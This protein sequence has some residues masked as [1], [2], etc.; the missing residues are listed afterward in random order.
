MAKRV[1]DAQIQRETYDSHESDDDMT[2]STKVA[3]S[4][5]MNRRKI[6]MPKRRMAFKSFTSASSDETKSANSFDTL[7][8]ANNTEGKTD[9]HLTTGNNSKLKALNF[10]FKTK[11]NDVISSKPLTDLRPLFAKYE[12]YIK[13]ILQASDK[14]SE[15]PKETVQENGDK[16][17]KVEDDRKSSDSSSEDEVK[18]EGPKFTIDSKPPTSDSVF[19]FG[20]KKENPQKD[21][22]DSESD[23]EIKGPEFKFSGALSSDVFKLNPSTDK[24]EKKIDANAKP[25]SFSSNA[26]NLTSGKTA[27]K[28]PFSFTESSET[29]EHSN[30]NIKPSFTFGAKDVGESQ[31]NKPSFAFGQ[32]AGKQSTEKSSFTFGLSK[33]ENKEDGNA[34]STSKSEN[35]GDDN[36]AKSSFTFPIPSKNTP[37]TTKPSFSFGVPNSSN[38]TS[39]PA[40]LFGT[41]TPPAKETNKNSGDGNGDKITPKPAFNFLSNTS[42]EKE[43]ENQG[44]SKPLFSFGKSNGSESKGSVN[45]T[46]PSEFNNVNEEKDVAKP[47]FSFG[48]NTNTAVNTDSKAPAFT[49]GS[50]TLADNKEDKKKPFSFGNSSSNDTPSFSFGKATAS[51]TTASSKSPAPPIPSTGFKFSLP[52]EQK[53]GQTTT[54]DSKKESTT[55]AAKND[56]QGTSK[57]EA[58][59]EESKPINLQNGEENEVAL[60]SERA[61]LMT[62]NADTKS[63]DSRGVGEMK[64]LKK[65]DDPSKVR[66]LCRS[67]GMGNI[68][69]NAT[70]VDSFKYEYLAPGNENLIKTPTVA[71]DGKLVTYI[72]KFKQK[73]EGRSF[74]KA[75]EDAKKEMKKE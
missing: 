46:F 21:E 41:A 45:S 19:S 40:L 67:D 56:S 11:V 60:F 32:T 36:N 64:L 53:G 29:N 57:V 72:V 70:V 34:V 7:K 26:S 49:F 44:D 31:K 1:A 17:A 65:K 30:D 23:I 8:Q 10:Q 16:P 12:I 48:G 20:P 13:N 15:N 18:V 50:S 51:S 73:E 3:S 38:D 58:A 28:N 9:N 5:V 4:T 71:A 63:Y 47:A 24:N 2:P 61:K 6:A 22:S 54:D 74:T 59:S 43:S 62:F 42:S 52:F 68:L 14:S 55:E 37:D 69:L 27:S 35:S 25:F 39:K 33:S 75:I 66:L